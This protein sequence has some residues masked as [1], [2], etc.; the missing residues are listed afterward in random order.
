MAV[1]SLPS[2]RRRP[3]SRAKALLQ[4]V[5]LAG[6]AS[7]SWIANGFKVGPNYSDPGAQVAPQWVDYQSPNLV[8]ED[9]DLSEWWTVFHDDTLTR[10]VV[11]ARHQNLGLKA[12]MAR[13]AAAAA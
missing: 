11:E 8:R 4:P 12:S 9:A 5:L 10:L 13:V 1:H 3:T 6:L 2:A 7:C